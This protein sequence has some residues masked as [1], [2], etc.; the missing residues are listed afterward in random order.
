[1]NSVELYIKLNEVH[2]NYNNAII[3]YTAEHAFSVIRLLVEIQ[4][5]I[6]VL[7]NTLVSLSVNDLAYSQMEVSH[8]ITNTGTY[9]MQDLQHLNNMAIK[10]G[11]A[12]PH[13]RARRS[14]DLSLAASEILQEYI[15][16][17]RENV[18]E[19]EGIDMNIL[20]NISRRELRNLNDFIETIST[21]LPY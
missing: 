20:F 21:K 10:S 6:E 15:E 14:I 4:N 9:I 11:I 13:D 5:Y 17:C 16:F 12:A 2:N 3:S 19:V 8:I 1:M 18:G 7:K